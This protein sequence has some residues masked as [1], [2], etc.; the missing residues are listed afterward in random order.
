MLVLLE[1]R[2]LQQLTQAFNLDQNLILRMA[3]R[4]GRSGLTKLQ[5]GTCLRCW[6]RNTQSSWP[7]RSPARCSWSLRGRF[8]TCCAPGTCLSHR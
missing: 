6:R 5:E 2:D 8:C 1:R 3:S 7:Q 4:H